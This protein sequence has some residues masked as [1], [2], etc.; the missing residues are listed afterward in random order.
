MKSQRRSNLFYLFGIH[1]IVLLFMTGCATQNKSAGLGGIIGATGGAALGGIADAGKDGKYRTRNVIVGATI[2]G[3]AG[4][5]AGSAL[6]DEIK[7]REAQAYSKGRAST[8]QLGWGG[9]PSLK[10]AKVESRW[11]EGRAVGNRY[12]E[13]HFEYIITEPTRLDAQ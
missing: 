6:H 3:M 5:I 11:I 9:M 2:G 7:T 8:P 12:I 13:G 1:L 4:L 10:G